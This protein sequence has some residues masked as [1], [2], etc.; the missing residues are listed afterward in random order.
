MSITG[1]GMSTLNEGELVVV[2]FAERELVVAELH[3]R[4]DD[5]T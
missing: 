5:L 2:G 1:L 4:G 3:T